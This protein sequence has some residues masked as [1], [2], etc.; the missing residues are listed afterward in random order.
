MKDVPDLKESQPAGARKKRKGKKEESTTASVE[1]GTGQFTFSDNGTYEG[2]WVKGPGETIKRHGRGK[3]QRGQMAYDGEW[4]D[5]V[6]QG[7]GTFKY[8]D[9][10]S[11]D[12]E[13]LA[14]KYEGIGTYRF[15]NGTRYEGEFHENKMSGKGVF[16]DSRGESWAGTF[17]NNTG[18]G[19]TIPDD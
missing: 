16:T 15:A 14:G 2:E 12:G 6:I 3:W 11:Y 10:S 1:K 18:P 19:L 9:G 5:D 13:W 8:P 4:R 7:R 17:F